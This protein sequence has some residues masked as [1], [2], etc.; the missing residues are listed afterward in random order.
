MSSG[1]SSRG[2]VI[3][4]DEEDLA[5]SGCMHMVT[6]GCVSPMVAT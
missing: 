2:L 4:V 3:F 1:C 6:D 5:V